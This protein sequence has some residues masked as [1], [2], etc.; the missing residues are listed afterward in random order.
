MPSQKKKTIVEKEEKKNI[1]KIRDKYKKV[2]YFTI[3]T[4]IFHFRVVFISI[5]FYYFYNIISFIIS[6]LK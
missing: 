6:F 2:L 5:A 1:K 4:F 3:V